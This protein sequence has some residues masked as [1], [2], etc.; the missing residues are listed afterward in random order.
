MFDHIL[1]PIAL[2][3]GAN[4]AR[5]IEIALRLKKEGGRITAL[6]VIEEVPPYISQYI[7][8]GQMEKNLEE[9][10]AQLLAE[11]G[12]VA[13]VHADV[14]IGHPGISITEYA[15]NKGVDLIVIASHRPGLQ[16]YFLGS[17]AAR[18]V[19]HATCSVH[20]VR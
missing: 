13:G 2:D 16:D 11:I 20:V 1:V 3:H 17:T 5:A 14:V 9:A 12:G 4:T 19:R 15:Q 10:R 18:V 8:E 6:T 7:P